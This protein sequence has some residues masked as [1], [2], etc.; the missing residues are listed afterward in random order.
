MDKMKKALTTIFAVLVIAC[1]V[2]GIIS[3][4]QK[5]KVKI[6][7]IG[8]GAENSSAP[9]AITILPGENK[10]LTIKPGVQTPWIYC[11]GRWSLDSSYAVEFIFKDGYKAVYHPGDNVDFGVRN[12]FSIRNISDTEDVTATLSVSHYY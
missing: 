2:F 12:V 10:V 8:A 3:L 7:E 5:D 4:I 6:P 9:Q 1:L 11:K